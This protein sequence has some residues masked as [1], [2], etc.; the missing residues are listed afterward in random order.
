[1]IK[2]NK[3]RLAYLIAACFF[4]NC[5]SF[6]G[7]MD[8]D[9]ES[10][11]SRVVAGQSQVMKYLPS[12]ELSLA[13]LNNIIETCYP[14]KE[15]LSSKA[16]PVKPQKPKN[17]SK[18]NSFINIAKGFS[19]ER[20]KYFMNNTVNEQMIT[21][22]TEIF[23]KSN[24]PAECGPP[25]LLFNF[26]LFIISVYIL[27]PRGSLPEA[28]VFSFW[29]NFKPAFSKAGFFCYFGIFSP[30]EQPLRA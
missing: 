15:G 2:T 21:A 28:V 9:E 24:L 26:L 16:N 8:I 19:M 23:E 13:L 27:L 18:R 3:K 11:L 6:V 12:W 10:A 7:Y 5:F 22:N 17:T 14:V 20:G 25:G 4:V 29:R 30:K 1:M